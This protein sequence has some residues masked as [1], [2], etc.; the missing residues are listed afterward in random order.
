MLCL[1]VLFKNE[2]S[3]EDDPPGGPRPYL[4]NPDICIQA[5]LTPPPP[6]SFFRWFLFLDHG[7]P[8]EK[9]MEFFLE[10]LDIYLKMI[11]RMIANGPNVTLLSPTLYYHHHFSG[12]DAFDT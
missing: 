1:G 5:S 8:K 2:E 3:W 10:E 4:F 12:L 7:D 6:G 11:G 9:K